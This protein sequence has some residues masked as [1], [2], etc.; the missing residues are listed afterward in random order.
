MNADGLLRSF[1]NKPPEEYRLYPVPVQIQQM[2]QWSLPMMP[3]R[4]EW[5]LFCLWV[6]ITINLF[7]RDFFS[8]SGPLQKTVMLRLFYIMSLG[9]PLQ[10]CL[11]KQHSG[12]QRK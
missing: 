9:G 12:L 8:I 11:L 6:P 3:K 7:R 5:I 1:M 10:T 2:I 4:S